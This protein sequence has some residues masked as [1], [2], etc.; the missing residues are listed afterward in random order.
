MIIA[1]LLAP[2]F[3]HAQEHEHQHEM[4]E[5]EEMAAEPAPISLP[6]SREGSGTSWMP[7]SSPMYAHHFIAGGWMLMLHYAVAL[8]YDDQWSGRGSR[9]FT[10][11]NW[12]MGMASRDLFGGQL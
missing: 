11:T 10:S 7:D 2:G 12:V 4:H 1:I 8:G 6:H 3:A 9:R 5:M